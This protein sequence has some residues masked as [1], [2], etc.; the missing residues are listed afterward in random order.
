MVASSFGGKDVKILRFF[1]HCMNDI[2][3]GSKD[4][5]KQRNLEPCMHDIELGGKDVKTLKVLSKETLN[6]A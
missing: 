3:L 2:R 4:G 6:L 5:L 1:G